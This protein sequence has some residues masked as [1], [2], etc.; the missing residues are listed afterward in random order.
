MLLQPTGTSIY[1]SSPH[2]YVADALLWVVLIV[3][4]VFAFFLLVEYLNTKKNY[5]LLWAMSFIAT[6]ILYHLV[7]NTGTFGVF[8]DS[9]STG[10]TIFIPGAIAAGLLYAIYGKEKKLFNKF[11]Y[12]GVYVVA[13]IVM[14]VIISILGLENVMTAF[15]AEAGD[16][17]YIPLTL[18]MIFNLINGIVLIVLPIYTTKKKETTTKALLITVGAI[19]YTIGGIFLAFIFAQA[20]NLFEVDPITLEYIPEE[21]MMRLMISTM[22]NTVVY[23][24]ACG[25]LL[26]AFGM[27]YGEKWRFNIPGI[28]FE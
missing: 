13:V 20:P 4:A 17:S 9:L 3:A 1:P 18:V 26:Y 24:L 21:F 2:S 19:L 25:T 14:F 11:S 10:F 28:D 27:L 5:H 8:N 12:G 6:F 16:Y 23:F 22:E 15:F 7:A